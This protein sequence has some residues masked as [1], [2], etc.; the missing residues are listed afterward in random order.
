MSTPNH[1]NIGYEVYRNT[2][3]VLK[4]IHDEH[5]DRVKNYLVSQSS[6]FSNI[7]DNSLP[8]VNSVWSLV[9]RNLPK[10]IFKFSICYINSLPTRRNLVKWGM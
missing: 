4:A 10:N 1:T 9:Q 7:I 8:K 3:M 6:F 2:K 5:E